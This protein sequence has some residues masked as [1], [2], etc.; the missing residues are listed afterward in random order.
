ME[1]ALLRKYDQLVTPILGAA[2]AVALAEACL[3]M[4]RHG[5]RDIVA[6]SVA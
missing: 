4:P 1:A 3:A 5:A 6:R 2:G